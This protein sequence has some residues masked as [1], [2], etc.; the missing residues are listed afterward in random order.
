M[1]EWLVFAA[2]FISLAA[3]AESR[4][5]RRAARMVEFIIRIHLLNPEDR[6]YLIHYLRVRKAMRHE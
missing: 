1:N 6:A 2:G 5:A 4:T 3:L